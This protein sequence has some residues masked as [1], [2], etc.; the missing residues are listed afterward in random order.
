MKAMGERLG[1]VLLL[2]VLAAC[3]GG[4]SGGQG[5]DDT[6]TGPD[7][8]RFDVLGEDL[9]AGELKGLDSEDPR[10]LGEE[11]PDVTV[12]PADAPN[13]D[14][15]LDVPQATDST[16]PDDTQ[17]LADE[18][19]TPDL[20]GP[21]APADERQIACEDSG[22]TWNAA[23]GTCACGPGSAWTEAGCVG[24]DA[25]GPYP[26]SR[27]RH[28]LERSGGL[29][30][31][32]IE[33]N[34]YLPGGEGPFPV[35]VF[36]HGYQLDPDDY[37]SYA[38]RLASWGYL[39]V[40]PQMPGGLTNHR[41]LA[42]H[43]ASIL[44][45][46]QS[47]GGVAGGPLGGQADRDAIGLAGHS[48]GGKISLLTASQDP[49]PKAVFGIDPVDAAGTP[50]VINPADWPSV[51][52]ERMGD[53]TVPLGLLGETIDGSCSGLLCQACAPAEDNF[54]AYFEHAQSPAVEIE[55]LG[56][57]HMSFLD[58]P[59]CGLACRL[60]NDR[61]DDP[62]LTRALTR[63]YLVAFFQLHLRGEESFRDYLVGP[64]M[65]ADVSAGLVTF[66]TKNGF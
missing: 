59:D 9:A 64:P 47:E 27:G 43:L 55:I 66:D 40:A 56:A 2:L 26:W 54:Q 48:L 38:E 7:A 15:G 20:P 36:L 62:A 33:L 19:S 8:P 35:V 65:A 29:F 42:E 10:D 53:I 32:T 12:P 57:N 1:T 34:I 6:A 21:D 5:S 18:S 13:P 23:A 63:K 41:T 4:A 25:Q 52:P 28:D 49:R 37:R 22:G 45:W 58:D 46:I 61:Q 44:D 31:T 16:S 60:C 14:A 17:A 24:P 11:P 50:I 39:V 30:G 3:G 51:T